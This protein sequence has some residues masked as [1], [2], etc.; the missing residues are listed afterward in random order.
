MDLGTSAKV[1]GSIPSGIV[2]ILLGWGNVPRNPDQGRR[3]GTFI[4]GEI[5]KCAKKRGLGLEFAAKFTSAF[6]K[7]LR[8]LVRRLLEL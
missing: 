5:V 7:S 1:D 2:D 6:A 3:Y 4:G 8:S